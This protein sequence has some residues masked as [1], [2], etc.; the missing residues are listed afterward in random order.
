MAHLQAKLQ[1]QGYPAAD[2]HYYQ[3]DQHDQLTAALEA[4]LQPADM[5]LL[6]A[7]H[8]L[9]LEQVLAAIKEQ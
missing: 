4:D 9:H 7:S 1:E 8:G 6:K 3:A 2:I 5:V